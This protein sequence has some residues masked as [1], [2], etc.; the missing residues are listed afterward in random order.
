MCQ[1][2][3]AIDFTANFQI[4]LKKSSYLPN[5]LQTN[6]GNP[7]RRLKRDVLSHDHDHAIIFPT[8]KVLP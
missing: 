3:I 5:V 6:P 1:I 2:T 8:S 7:I 4:N